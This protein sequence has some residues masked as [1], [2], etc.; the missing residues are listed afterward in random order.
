M[1]VKKKK[2]SRRSN[3]TITKI[4]DSEHPFWTS[5]LMDGQID[6]EV[7]NSNPPPPSGTRPLPSLKVGVA[8]S[9]DSVSIHWTPS[10]H[11]LALSQDVIS[12]ISK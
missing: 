9:N 6:G 11:V 4:F 12:S 10:V 5:R 2:D 3:Q 1:S 8:L 7:I